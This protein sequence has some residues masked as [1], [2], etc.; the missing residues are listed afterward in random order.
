VL[1]T[2]EQVMAIAE[3]SS[4]EF[5]SWQGTDTAPIDVLEEV[6]LN[7]RAWEELSVEYGVTNPDP[8]WKID[9]DATCDMLAADSCVKPY[10]EVGPG[11]CVLPSL[12]RRA[13]EDD[14]S[15]T[16]Y[17]DV[18]F[19]ERQLLALAHSMLKRGLFTEEELARHIKEVGE[20]LRSV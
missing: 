15:E 16:I 13:E 20:R 3:N 12:E 7:G 4:H 11:T 6:R 5:K 9:L 1:K 2:K 8:P 17:A 10:S 19:P 14:L 18:P